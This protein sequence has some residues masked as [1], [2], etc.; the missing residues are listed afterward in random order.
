MLKFCYESFLIIALKGWLE[1]M[2][3]EITRRISF[4]LFTICLCLLGTSGSMKASGDWHKS[5]CYLKLENRDSQYTRCNSAIIAPG[6]DTRVNLILLSQNE[7]VKAP[8]SLKGQSIAKDFG[9][10]F[11]NN[12]Y[13]SSETFFIFMGEKDSTRGYQ[14][15]RYTV[16]HCAGLTGGDTD[17]YKALDANKDVSNEDKTELIYARRELHKICDG[18][19]VDDIQWPIDISNSSGLSFLTYLQ[20]SAHFYSENWDQA[21]K[22]FKEINNASDP[23]IR[24]VTSYMIG[25]NKLKKTW[26]LALDKWGN[27][28]G[29]R[30]VEKEPLSEAN[31]AFMSYLLRYPNGQYNSSAQGLLRRLIWLSGDEEGLARE[32]IRQL[33]SDKFPSANKVTLIKE[34]DQK[35][36]PLRKPLSVISPV[37]LATD[38]LARMRSYRTI[39]YTSLS[40]AELSEQKEH[41]KD[42]MELYTFLQA[43]FAFYIERDAQ[44]VLSLIPDAASQEN[45][46]PL[47]FSRQAL[48]GMALNI[49]SDPSEEDFWKKMLGGTNSFYQRPVVE[50]ALAQYYE[51]NAQLFKV[52]MKGSMI[53]DSYIR[54]ILLSKVASKK[55]LREQV[56]NIERP[57]H[58]RDL[59]LFVLLDKELSRGHYLDFVKDVEQVTTNSSTD[60]YL[61]RLYS[62]YE[63]PVGKFNKG[64]W[65]DN[66]ECPKIRATALTLAYEPN[67]VKALLCLG[68]F[69]RLNGFDGHHSTSAPGP[70][71]V[72]RFPGRAILRGSIYS[73]IIE[74][75]LAKDEEMAYALYRAVLCYAPVGNNS[76]GGSVPVTTRKAWFKLLKGK[77]GSSKWA[78]GL[79][80]YW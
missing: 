43:T 56:K 4:I 10:R 5:D 35:L 30:F 66:F 41:F 77:Y 2:V 11:L 7:M 65:S 39:G 23:W 34:I 19:R 20:A 59:A 3:M 29:L 24:E 31:Q 47:E 76:C 45:F 78:K 9:N 28:K 80:Y 50:L 57:K 74:G 40:K 61:W 8:L 22:S 38:D 42:H 49:L 71:G 54:K 16:A 48:R 44:K 13:F 1:Q 25:R 52:F 75:S 46:L 12:N 15:W 32:Y 53:N 17:F 21:D 73:N 55:M 70:G 67:N 69:Y 62:K 27:F 18:K 72:D 6:N 33:K 51:K 14:N 36:L 58:E 64:K 26:D 79:K 68:D 63:I 60:G 37:L